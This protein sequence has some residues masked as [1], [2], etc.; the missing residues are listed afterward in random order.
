[1]QDKLHNFYKKSRQDRI[2]ILQELTDLSRKEVEQLNRFGALGE[3]TADS[4]I[5]NVVSSYELPLGIATNVM[6][7]GTNYLV[8][9]AIEESSVV[10]ACSYMAKLAKKNGGVKAEASEPVMIG[11]IELNNVKN[12]ERAR[13]K[14]EE[15]K[16]KVVETANAQDEVLV[17]FGGGVN[18]IEVRDIPKQDTIV[19][20]LLVNVQD[21]MGANAVNSMCEAVA[22]LLEE[23]T[24]GQANLRILSNLAD[25]RLVTAEVK[26]NPKDLEREDLDFSGEEVIDGI[27]DAYQFAAADPYRATTHNKGIMNGIDAVV[28]ATGNDFRAIESGAHAYAARSGSYKP[29]T[30]WK[31]TEKGNLKGEIELPLALGT[32]GGATKIHPLA[33]IAIKIL[34]VESAQELAEVIAAVGLLQNLGALRALAAEGIQRGHMKL[35]AKNLAQQAGAKGELVDKIARKMV[36]AEEINQ[37]KAEE[38]L[39][40][41]ET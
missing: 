39:N 30:S 23:I 8:P 38:L 31:K 28:I 36:E 9:M 40:K 34:G 11:Q 15:N 16:Q 19:V 21:A 18:E 27:V 26:L 25:R 7:N 2:K 3:E 12:Y 4:M 20:H 6:V 13:E 22:P 33:R 41:F 1:M 24:G 10:A 17:K 29:L 5:E 35:H 37:Q 14:I 32:V